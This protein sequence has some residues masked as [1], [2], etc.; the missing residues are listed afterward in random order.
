MSHKEYRRN[1]SR[2][3]MVCRNTKGPAMFGAWKPVCKGYDFLLWFLE[4]YMW[5]RKDSLRVKVIR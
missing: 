5:V 2:K 4:T 3:G 1:R